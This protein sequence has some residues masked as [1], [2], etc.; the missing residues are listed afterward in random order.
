MLARPSRPSILNSDKTTSPS[1]RPDGGQTRHRVD[2]T[3]MRLTPLR[4]LAIVLA[5]SLPAGLLIAQEEPAPAPVEEPA[6]PVD[7]QAPPA[8]PA[9]GSE[10]P[11]PTAEENAAAP[12]DPLEIYA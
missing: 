9:P 8:E 12:R 7:D 10:E 6:P 3:L 4:T 11:E 5:L 2:R 1:I